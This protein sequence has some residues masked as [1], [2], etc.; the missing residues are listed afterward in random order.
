MTE[1]HP[2]DLSCDRKYSRNYVGSLVPWN[3]LFCF[4]LRS[5]LCVVKISMSFVSIGELLN[6]VNGTQVT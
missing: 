6:S 4:F 2:D 1:G 3:A 5:T